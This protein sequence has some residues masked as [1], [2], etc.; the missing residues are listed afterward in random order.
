MRPL[1]RHAVVALVAISCAVACRIAAPRPQPTLATL[2]AA[3]PQSVAPG[4]IWLIFVDELHLDFRG[5][6]YL[7]E[8]LKMIASELIQD[9]DSFAVRSTPPSSLAIDVTSDRTLF[10]KAIR[11]TS[12]A[13]LSPVDLL[14]VAPM[15]G[16]FPDEVWYRANIAL[17]AAQEAI[18]SVER[19]DSGRRALIYISNGY[20][21]E[22][23]SEASGA[24][25][26]AKA[27]PSRDSSVA[28]LRE[29]VSALTRLAKAARIRIFAIDPRGLA[30]ASRPD[31]APDSPRWAPY[32]ATT[33]G[34]LRFIAEQTGGFVE[35]EDLAGSLKRISS[36]MREQP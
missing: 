3:A 9:G 21:F 22:P 8:L 23:F 18:K 32:L 15:P 35:Y 31:L 12:G 33:R 5:T 36:A 24:P 28:R 14:S 20:N 17:A 1:A 30:P 11:K 4:T 25:S 26:S 6:G 27:S 7:R 29:Q 19:A 16:Q 10:E 2:T 13:G 34:S